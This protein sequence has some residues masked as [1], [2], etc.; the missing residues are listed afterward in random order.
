MPSR[1]WTD[2][3]LA[4]AVKYSNKFTEVAEYLGT[5]VKSASGLKKLKDTADQL[6][7]DYSHFVRN[8]HNGGWDGRRQKK[9]DDV[10]FAENVTWN[11]NIRRRYLQLVEYKCVICKM[12]EW[13]GGKLI[14]QID[15]IDGNRLNNKLSNLRLLCPNCHSQTATW[16]IN[17]KCLIQRNQQC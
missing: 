11:A 12:N 16:G 1:R 6:Q 4:E 14:L 5:S 7:I 10:I 13:L 3:D 9:S 8:K 17:K 15:H 2:Q